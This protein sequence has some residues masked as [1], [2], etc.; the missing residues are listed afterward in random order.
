MEQLTNTQKQ[1]LQVIADNNETQHMC[2]IFAT[3]MLLDDIATVKHIA[4]NYAHMFNEEQ[5]RTA[6]AI[7]E[8]IVKL[9]KFEAMAAELATATIAT[10]MQ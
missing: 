9:E 7:L 8:E 5:R 4:V 3:A 6:Q 1:M 10:A 2:L